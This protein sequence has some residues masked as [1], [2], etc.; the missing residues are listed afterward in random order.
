VGC[1]RFSLRGNFARSG[2]F[3]VQYV[4]LRAES[5]G[6]DAGSSSS[7][8]TAVDSRALA[9]PSNLEGCHEIER[10]DFTETAQRLRFAEQE[11]STSDLMRPY[12]PSSRPSSE[13]L[14]DRIGTEDL[15][16]RRAR[17]EATMSNSARP[18][19]QP[20]HC[21]RAS[22]LKQLSQEDHLHTRRSAAD[23]HR[24][25]RPALD[26]DTF[27]KGKRQQRQQQKEDDEDEDND[28][29]DGQP[30]Q[31]VDNVAA[32]LTAERVGDTHLSSKGDESARP[33][34]RQRPLPYGESDEDDERPRPAKRK[35]PSS[36]YDGPT[37]RKR[38]HHLQPRSP[39]QRRPHFKSHQHYLKSHSLLDQGSRV[40]ASSS[41]EGRLP[42]PAPSA[43][44]SM[45][46]EMLSDC[47]NLGGSSGDT[48]STLIKVTFRLHPPHYCSFVAVIQ[49]DRDR[50]EFSFGQ[51]ARLVENIGHVGKI[52]D[53]TIKPIQQHLFLLT[54]FSQH[55]SF[56]SSF[57][58]RTIGTA[59]EAGCIHRDAMRTRLQHGRAVD[60][61][62]I[63]SRG[64]E[65]SSSD[66]DGG[67]SDSD[68]DPSSDDNGCS[69]EDEQRR[70]STRKHS[71]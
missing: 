6:P 25:V 44:Q 11:A 22:F 30:Q 57:S 48:L 19:S 4:S 41:A 39:R 54:G 62:A 70:L 63:A 8:E 10:N 67:L 52:D 31:K 16:T 29:D 56:R 42:S 33:S 49:D 40:A 14:H 37:Q 26:T 12:G 61:R 53:F 13:P 34:K 55:T 58:R 9:P 66:D 45:D 51:L 2:N 35:R 43:L 65:P 38:K 68:P 60:G 3:A 64:S 28:E 46:T 23:E 27:G 32:V 5:A 59:A 69:S 71:P 7:P 24:L 21:S 17:S 20:L 15:Y 50:P 1:R 18:R 36:S 47:C